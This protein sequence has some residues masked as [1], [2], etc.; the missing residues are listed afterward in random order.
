[1]QIKGAAGGIREIPRHLLVDA[2][3]FE[4]LVYQFV[5]VNIHLV[6]QDGK[7]V[8]YCLG[9]VGIG[10]G[11]QQHHDLGLRHITQLGSIQNDI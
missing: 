8:K 6:R 9:K 4:M 11:L 2:Q 7:R 3:F 5:V 10:V 1:M